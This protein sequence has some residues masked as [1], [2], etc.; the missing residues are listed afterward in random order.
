MSLLYDG[1]CKF[2]I[3]GSERLARLAAPGVVKRVSS[4]DEEEMARFPASVREGIG[5]AL[6]L[7]SADGEIASGAAAV[8]RVL[9]TRRVWRLITWLYWVPG[10]RQ[11]TDVLYKVVARNRYRIMGK[12]DACETGACPM[13]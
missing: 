4:N 5:G 3:A 6:Q 10:I 7:V 2:C 8:N 1:S 9:A 11:V 12:A 13:P